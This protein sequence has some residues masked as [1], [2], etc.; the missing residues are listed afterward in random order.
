MQS[1]NIL[2]EIE[3]KENRCK[4]MFLEIME[5]IDG[6]DFLIQSLVDNKYTLS[7]T[8][9]ELE[10]EDQ[11]HYTVSFLVNT[12]YGQYNENTQIEAIV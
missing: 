10:R 5:K 12:V 3:V 2:R 8:N 6:L 4:R 11:G 9:I 7:I 1:F